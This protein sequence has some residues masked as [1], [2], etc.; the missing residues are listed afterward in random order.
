LRRNLD[1]LNRYL[2]GESEREIGESYGISQQHVSRIIRQ[3][4]NPTDP[5]VAATIRSG[6]Q[7]DLMDLMERFV[8]I[9]LS[10]DLPPVYGKD[11]VILRDEKGE[12]VRDIRPLVAAAKVALAASTRLGAHLGTDAAQKIEAT[13]TTKVI[14]EGVDLGEL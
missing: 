12:I 6:M 2:N 14:I 11:D 8:S 9:A 10:D 7:A 5:D 13:T 1:I 4:Q 3:L